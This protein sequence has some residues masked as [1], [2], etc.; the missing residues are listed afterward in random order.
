MAL[1]LL[2][3]LVL[4]TIRKKNQSK[5]CDIANHLNRKLDNGISFGMWFVY[6]RLHPQEVECGTKIYSSST[7][8]IRCRRQRNT[9]GNSFRTAE[10]L[11]ELTNG[12]RWKCNVFMRL[13]RIPGMRLRLQRPSDPEVRSV[14]DWYFKNKS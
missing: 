7:P 1:I 5:F 2:R 14:R 6:N 8:F 11:N 10:R 13:R 12:G 9:I 4:P 3:T